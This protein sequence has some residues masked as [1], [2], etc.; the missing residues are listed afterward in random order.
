MTFFPLI[1]LIK[2]SLFSLVGSVN[3]APGLI[4]FIPRWK[5]QHSAFPPCTIFSNVKKKAVAD[6]VPA[7]KWRYCHS[8]TINMTLYINYRFLIGNLYL[9]ALC[10][11]FYEI[12]SATRSSFTDLKSGG[13]NKEHVHAGI[14]FS[15]LSKSYTKLKENIFCQVNPSTWQIW[16]IKMLI[17][18][19]MTITQVCS[20]KKPI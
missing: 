6:L 20:T 7:T 17:Q 11:I 1:F 3:R 4:K 19:G 8:S 15:Y 12:H 5:K 14:T 16:H 2:A 18:P 10:I 13:P 9:V